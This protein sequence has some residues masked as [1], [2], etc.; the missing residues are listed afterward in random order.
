MLISLFC[1]WLCVFDEHADTKAQQEHTSPRK[2]GRV[3]LAGVRSTTSSDDDGTSLNAATNQPHRLCIKSLAEIK[4][5]K[6]RRNK[7]T[8]SADKIAKASESQKEAQRRQGV[9]LNRQHPSAASTD[10]KGIYKIKLLS[11]LSPFYD[12]LHH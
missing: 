2:E 3:R 8:D 12:C 7:L 10:C 6:E 9:N 11:F 5:E 1:R 4:L